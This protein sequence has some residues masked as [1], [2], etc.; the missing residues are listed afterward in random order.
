MTIACS[1]R[2]ND[3]LLQLEK[4]LLLITASNR[5]ADFLKQQYRY[6]RL[7][8]L[9]Q[10]KFQ[11]Q[12]LKKK[13]KEVWY[14]PAIVTERQWTSTLFQ[15]LMFHQ[16]SSQQPLVLLSDL[17]TRLLWEKAVETEGDFLLDKRKTADR[18]CQ[19]ATSLHQWLLSESLELDDSFHW[20]KETARFKVWHQLV[21]Q[22]CKDNHWLT[23]YELPAFLAEHF[24]L[25]DPAI[26]WNLLPDHIGLLGFQQLTPAKQQLIETL[27]QMGSDFIKLEPS[28]LENETLSRVRIECANSSDEILNSAIWA[29]K[30]WQEEPD[31][32]IAVIIP[33]LN[34]K[35]HQVQH[36]FDKVFCP[37]RLL[38]NSDNNERPFDISLGN[39]LNTY[40]LIDNGLNLLS[41]TTHSLSQNEVVQFMQ[42]PFLFSEE[43]REHTHLF[44]SAIRKSR[45]ANFN[46]KELKFIASNNTVDDNKSEILLLFSLLEKFNTKGRSTPAQWAEKWA[47]LTDN[48]L[49]LEKRSLTSS[50]Y[51]TREAWYKRLEQMAAF[52]QLLGTISWS[53]FRKL[54]RRLISETLFQPKTGDLSVQIMG[55]LEAVSLTFDK[56]RI[57][58]I[59]NRLW[60]AKA[61]PNP[62]LPYDLQKRHQMPNATAE[63]ELEVS[64]QLLATLQSSAKQVIFS[65]S[66]IDGEQNLSV[67]PLLEDLKL[68]TSENIKEFSPP[69]VEINQSTKV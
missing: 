24:P 28:P 29:K 17:Q 23:S 38:S 20:R 35:R 13:S 30:Q 8:K 27:Q 57:C 9:Q 4:G 46:L 32:R 25:C 62:F 58:G 61:N 64:Q 12:R 63:R 50:E 42:S 33:N 60:P 67:S 59:D 53:E 21:K 45:Q 41:L 37:E 34:E 19:A 39:N 65:H 6:F 55:I 40:P 31:E 51:Q 22:Q 15:H 47:E 10:N 68:V 48:L 11:P 69:A 3:I 36:I 2:W 52:D 56:I 1:Q 18:A 16:D 7:Q 54:F 49:W 5:Q 44:I 26:Q 14:K 66:K 43:Q